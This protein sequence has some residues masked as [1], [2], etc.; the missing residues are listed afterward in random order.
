MNC[1]TKYKNKFNFLYGQ[2]LSKYESTS[3]FLSQMFSGVTFWF[4]SS[5]IA[6]VCLDLD[7]LSPQLKPSLQRGGSSASLHNSTMRNTIFQLMIHTLDPLGDGQYAGTE[8]ISLKCPRWNAIPT[9]PLSHPRGLCHF[10][11]VH[12]Q[13][14]KAHDCWETLMRGNVHHLYR[15]FSTCWTSFSACLKLWTHDCLSKALNRSKHSRPVFTNSPFYISQWIVYI[16]L[17]CF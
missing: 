14:S 9:G 10:W 16:R 5:S 15:I 3:C 12:L 13:P 11:G 17:N 8:M 1:K 6:S 7:R 4:T 2:M